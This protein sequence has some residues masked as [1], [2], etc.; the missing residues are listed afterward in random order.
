MKKLKSLDVPDV[1]KDVK[2]KKLPNQALKTILSRFKLTEGELQLA[3][4]IEELKKQ[5]QE[6]GEPFLARNRVLLKILTEANEAI[7]KLL[8]G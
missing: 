1:L 6:L 5:A 3:E 4:P 2:A 8:G 7:E